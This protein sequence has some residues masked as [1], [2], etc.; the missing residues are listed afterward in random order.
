MRKRRNEP[1]H[2]KRRK[3]G[4][5]ALILVAL[6]GAIYVRTASAQDSSAAPADQSAQDRPLVADKVSATQPQPAQVTV[7]G[8][9]NTA[10]ADSSADPTPQGSG[11]AP[12]ASSLLPGAKP[13]PDPVAGS[14]AAAVNRGFWGRFIKAYY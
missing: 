6:F 14:A 10:D 12:V 9:P 4:L 2:P 7:A 5:L 13:V 8:T 1:V 11:A 3:K